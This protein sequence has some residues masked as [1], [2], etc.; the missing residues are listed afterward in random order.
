MKSRMTLIVVGA[1]HKTGAPIPVKSGKLTIN[2]GACAP[3]SM[4]LE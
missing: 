2:L 1:R 4:I 3:E